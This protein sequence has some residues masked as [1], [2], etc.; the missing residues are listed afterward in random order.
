MRR[1][2]NRNKITGQRSWKAN[3]TILLLALLLIGILYLNGCGSATE[4][5]ESKF[6]GT[7]YSEE[8]NQEIVVY[9]NATLEID[10]IG[11]YTWN[12]GTYNWVISEDK[13]LKIENEV[14]SQS[15]KWGEKDWN[16]YDEDMT[17]YLD[18][19][20][21]RLNETIYTKGNRSSAMKSNNQESDVDYEDDTV[22]ENGYI[23]IVDGRDFSEGAAW[24]YGDNGIWYCIDTEGKILFELPE[25]SEPNEDFSG[26]ISVIDESKVINISGGII[27]DAEKEECTLVYDRDKE[28]Y[29]FNGFVMTTKS[30]DSFEVTEEQYGILNNEGN[31]VIELTSEYG[32]P[33]YRGS[34]IFLLK[35]YDDN[36]EHDNIYFNA[37]TNNT[38]IRNNDYD[39]LNFNRGYAISIDYDGITTL[40]DTEGIELFSL[41]KECIYGEVGDGLV[42]LS[43][44]EDFYREKVIQGFYDTS[45]SMVIDLSEYDIRNQPYFTEGYAFLELKNEQESV[46]ATIIDT[47]GNFQFEP[48]KIETDSYDTYISDGLLKVDYDEF[49]DMQGNIVLNLDIFGEVYNFRN[50]IL[51]YYEDGVGYCNKQGE[52]ILEKLIIENEKGEE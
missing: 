16:E 18:D 40:V 29:L 31:W 11:R 20:Y 35:K 22:E 6:E 39:K 36:G 34:A 48:K 7:W 2:N 17:W 19:D 26:G 1:K 46:F 50:S 51:R 47:K 30:I 5:L 43:Y 25:G 10:D 13:H 33:S 38:F 12:D 23:S 14:G 28:T 49:M 24:V 4:S 32:E 8:G 44:Y 15:F 41:D 52:Q 37:S 9:N 3:S 42:F 21:F 27:F 45:G